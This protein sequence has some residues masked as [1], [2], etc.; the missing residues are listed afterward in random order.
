VEL[1][2]AGL[3]EANDYLQTFQVFGTLPRWQVYLSRIMY[4]IKPSYRP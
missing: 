4:F 1:D 2:T 3:H